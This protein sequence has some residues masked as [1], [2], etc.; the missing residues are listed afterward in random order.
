MAEG[1]NQDSNRN[2][3]TTAS[4][5]VASAF[6]GDSDGGAGVWLEAQSMERRRTTTTSPTL[7]YSSVDD[8]KL[9]S[10]HHQPPTFS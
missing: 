2:S 8:G 4:D 7:L 3:P 10:F 1:F 6:D 9:I 5:S